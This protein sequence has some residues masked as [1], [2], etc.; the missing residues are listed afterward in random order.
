[1]NGKAIGKVQVCVMALLLAGNTTFADKNEQG[2]RGGK[3]GAG[4]SM[5][6]RGPVD[7]ERMVE[8]MSR[9]LE[10]DETQRQELT[11]IVLAAEPQVSELQARMR[12]NHDAVASLDVEDA[13]YSTRIGTLALESGQ[14]A[15]EMTLLHAQIRADI[16]LNLSPEQ[17]QKMAAGGHRMRPHYRDHSDFGD[18]AKDNEITQ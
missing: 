11:N 13:N 15:T 4:H 1:M 9:W 3:P 7:P 16:H 17:Q 2:D 14:I 10:L 5:M 12:S 8:R 18:H 6:F